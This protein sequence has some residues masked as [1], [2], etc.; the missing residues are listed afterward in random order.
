M[1]TPAEKRDRSK[2]C[3]YHRDFGHTTGD[4]HQLQD[5]IEDLIQRGHLRYFVQSQRVGATL[6]GE[7]EDRPASATIS[8]AMTEMTG[9]IGLINLAPSSRITRDPLPK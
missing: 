5:A 2:Y 1:I 7:D 6:Q 8:V 9:M 4:C 3:E